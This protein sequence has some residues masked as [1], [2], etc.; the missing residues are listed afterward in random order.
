M[1]N[2]ILAYAPSVGVLTTHLSEEE[3]IEFNE[4]DNGLMNYIW[5]F[6]TLS[7]ADESTW[8]DP[9]FMKTDPFCRAITHNEEP[10]PNKSTPS[11]DHFCRVH[12]LHPPKWIIGTD[13]DVIYNPEY[14]GRK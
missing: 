12:V 13:G 4:P 3:L 1:T 6:A 14:Q 9:N 10:C 11:N 5:F 8:V 2:I 7:P